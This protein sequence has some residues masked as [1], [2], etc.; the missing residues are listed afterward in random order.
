MKRNLE[1]ECINSLIELD[2]KDTANKTMPL[3]ATENKAQSLISASLNINKL[4]YVP[5]PSAEALV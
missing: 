2:N 4:W 5:N 1:L 3:H